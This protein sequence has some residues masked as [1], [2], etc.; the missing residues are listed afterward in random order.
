[1]DYEVMHNETENRFEV[2][3]EGLLSVIEYTIAGNVI[4]IYHTGVPKELS[5]RGIAAALAKAVL[6]FAKNEN[7]EV[8]PSCSYVKAYI[9]RHP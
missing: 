1:M 2:E 3:V 4:D 8:Q 6:E 5:G 7:L 9:E